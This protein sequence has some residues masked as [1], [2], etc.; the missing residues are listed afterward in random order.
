MV[1][2]KAN[3]AMTCQFLLHLG[4]LGYAFYSCQMFLP[5]LIKPLISEVQLLRLPLLES[6]LAQVGWGKAFPFTG[7]VGKLFKLFSHSDVDDRYV[8]D[9]IPM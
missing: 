4:C 8:A 9:R 7:S 3:N 1:T 5:P 2:F 6:L